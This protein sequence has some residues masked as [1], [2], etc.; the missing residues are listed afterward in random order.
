[1]GLR[2]LILLAGVVL[3]SGCTS[4]FEKIIDYKEYDIFSV[5]DYGKYVIRE[6]DTDKDG[7][8]D[9]RCY[10]E[11]TDTRGEQ[12]F[13]ELMSVQEDRNKNGVFEDN[14]FLYKRKSR[15]TEKKSNQNPK[16]YVMP[17]GLSP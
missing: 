16:M 2:K 11:R 3:I 4:L 9:L 6:W 7:N 17:R 10:Y 12:T 8:N 1:M 5:R 13:F 15:V 14:E